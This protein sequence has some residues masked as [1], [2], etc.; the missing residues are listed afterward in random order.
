MIIECI[1]EGFNLTN[2][3]LSLVVIRITVAI[4]NLLNLIVFLGLPLIAAVVY[5]G[6]DLTHAR[7]L[8]PSLLENPFGFVTRY[9]GVVFLTGISLIFYLLL[10]SLLFLYALG[11]TLG[12]LKNSAVNIRYKFSLSSFFK[13]ANTAFFRLFW[14]LCLVLLG[15]TVLCLVFMIFGGI[16]SAVA[17]GAAASDSALELFLNSFVMLTVAIFSIII[18]LAGF[19]FT[20]YSMMIM[21]IEG[22]GVT[23]SIRRALNFLKQMPQAF[24]F[25]IILLIGSVA[26]HTILYGLQLSFGVISFIS[27]LAYFINAFIQGYL[28]IFVWASLIVYYLKTTK[29]PVYSASYEI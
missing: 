5:L 15:V 19:I 11:G 4:I 20:V 29:Y 25:Y 23:D 27:P 1:K 18:A 22:K 9:L 17:Q 10:T 13:E 26:L 8:L 21:V 28:T 3:N 12:V 6:F 16:V 24:L 14:F 2:K 7:D